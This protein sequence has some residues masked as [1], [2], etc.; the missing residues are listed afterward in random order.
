MSLIYPNVLDDSIIK[1]RRRRAEV[2]VF[3]ALKNTQLYS[4]TKI[5]YSCDWLNTVSERDAQ[6]DGEC[7]FIITDTT[8]GVIF[9]EVKGGFI[10]KDDQGNWY[11]NNTIEIKNPIQQALKSKHIIIREWKKRWKEKNPHKIAPRVFYGHYVIL[12]DSSNQSGKDLGLFANIKQFGFS[13]DMPNIHKL[14]DQFFDY[15]PVGQKHITYDSLGE[16][17]QDLFHEM[18]T[19]PLD[20]EPLLHQKVKINNFKIELLTENQQDLIN[21]SVG[22]WNRL[23]VEG[24]AGSGKTSIALKK[25]ELESSKVNSSA[26]ICR[27]KN[28]SYKIKSSFKN[29]DNNLH[30]KI[31]TFD[32]FILNIAKTYFTENQKNYI[33]KELSKTGYTQKLREF[34]INKA[35]DISED[36]DK[37][38]FIVIDESQDFEDSW[39]LLINEIIDLNTVIWIFGDSN[40]NIWKTKKP[41]ISNLSE[42]FRLKDVLRNSSQ[43]ANQS[44]VFY[45]GKGHGVNI[46]GPYSSEVDIIKSKDIHGS[47]SAKINELIFIQSIKSKSITIL[48]NANIHEQILQL[49]D[50][51]YEINKDIKFSNSIFLS[52]IRNF[53]GLESDCVILIVDNLE[54]VQDQDFYIGISRAIS[55]LAI[56]TK[57]DMYEELLSRLT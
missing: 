3:N 29:D 40:Q 44:I 28:L 50:E 8:L 43:I 22:K 32:G 23:W 12:P 57:E 21:Q 51:R 42:S 11:T 34:I 39:W 33:D 54:D 55:Y 26:F 17:G 20:F 37:Y 47:L 6:S 24:P 7:D 38:D 31:F 13:E 46:S 35:F 52:T 49:S 30:E 53:K 27:G 1:D 14:V 25:F 16:S 5:Y 19:K 41:E 15:K 2:L 45:N 56:I 10:S 9:I 18:F 4:T 48:A 36:I